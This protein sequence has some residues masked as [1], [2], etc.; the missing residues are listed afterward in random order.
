MGI[1]QRQGIKNTLISYTGIL[2]GFVSL[3]IIQPFFL[4][5]EEIGLT[6]VLFSFSFLLASFAGLGISN[7]TI[8]FFPQFKARDQQHH[9]F[10]GFVLLFPLF[11]ILITSILIYSFSSP[12]KALY[13]EKSSLFNDYYFYAIPFT[14]FI[15]LFI[16]LTNYCMALF[17]STVPSL[18]ND[19]V[20]RALLLMLIFIYA[21]GWISLSVFIWG[22]I[23]I[24]ACLSAALLFY[25]YRNDKPGL[26][27]QGDIWSRSMLKHML[28]F[29]AIFLLAGTASMGIKLLDSVI[30]GQFISLD[31]VGVYAIAAFIPTFIEAPG[32]ALDKIAGPRIAD[33]MVKKDRDE[34]HKIYSLSSRYLF[35]LGALLFLLVNLNIVDLLGF[36]PPI[37]GQGAEV[38][39]ILSLSALFNLV[40]GSN[41]A[42]VFNSDRFY[43]G[44]AVLITIALC[45]LGLLYLFIP[46]AGIEGAAWAVCISS[47]VY[48]L[49]K[50]IFIRIRFGFQ[51]FGRYTL[52]TFVSLVLLYVLGLLLPFH[53]HPVVNILLRS[54]LIGATFI[55]VM[56]R[57]GVFPDEFKQ[58]NFSK[59]TS[60][61]K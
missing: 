25:I 55:F 32:N 5:A 48:N 37:Y 24:Y 9:G 4:T 43:L 34:I 22:Y 11:G 47:I 12:F 17:K 19:V 8:R 10:L 42:L 28:I 23:V 15:A 29:G 53:F 13:Q 61:L 20:Q 38:V 33:A 21:F 39:S 27:P 51:P 6:R 46:A 45:T 14:F 7:I 16:A 58:L 52:V 54:L 41:N 56:F 40:T 3:V 59:F 36:L 18:L 44:V 31:L 1:I 26:I 60:R 57:L 49:F 35:A 30:L 2:L 50:F